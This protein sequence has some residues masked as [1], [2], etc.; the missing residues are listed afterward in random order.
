KAEIFLSRKKRKR[1]F[2]EAGSGD[3]FDEEFRD[4]F[5]GSAVD[6][7]IER[8]DAAKGGNRVACQG[9]QVCVSER[10]ALGGAARIV[11]LDDDGGGIAKFGREAARGFEVDE[12]VVGEFFSLELACG[13]ES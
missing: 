8:Q 2:V 10:G 6:D 12:I 13:G 9:F 7:A 5:R 3:A 4:F 11:V 1:L